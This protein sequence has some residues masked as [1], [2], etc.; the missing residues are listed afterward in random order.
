MPDKVDLNKRITDNHLAMLLAKRGM[1]K[2]YVELLHDYAPRSRGKEYSPYARFYLDRVSNQRIMTVSIL[3]RV[4]AAGFSIAPKWRTSGNK[5]VAEENCFE[6]E[7][8]G[9]SAKVICVNDQPTGVKKNDFVSWR[10]QI[11]FN[12]VEQHCG[13][14][15]WLDTDSVN[16]NYHFNTLEW[17]YGICKRRL[18]IIEGRI[19]GYWIFASNPNGEVH[20]KY[21]QTGDYKLKLDEYKINDDEEVIPAS[22]FDVAEYPF[23]VGDSSTFYPDANPETSSVDGY[24]YH[25]DGDGLAW[26]TIIAAAGTAANDSITYGYPA[27]VRCDDVNVNKWDNLPRSFYLSDTS[28]LGAGAEVTAAIFSIYG[29]DKLDNG[30]VTPDVNIYSSAPASNTGIVAGDFDSLGSTA[31]C[32]TTITYA[33]W[34][35]AGYNDFTLNGT[36]RAAIV[37]DGVTKFG[38]RNANYDVA[39]NAPAWTADAWSYLE[40]YFAEKGAGKQPKLVVTYTPPYSPSS[41]PTSMAA[42]LMAARAI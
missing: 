16:L 34:N 30:G 18:R 40:G 12:G 38:A 22:V 37:V 25:Y 7:V 5:F 42:K 8:E 4:T 39:A 6:A 20:I 29:S 41:R 21:N 27:Y 35:T 33:G 23:R 36:G 31:F 32:N 9:R 15:I 26:A 14:P 17:D 13:N 2:E 24:A 28:P 3:P 10:P 1:S 19:H 11:F